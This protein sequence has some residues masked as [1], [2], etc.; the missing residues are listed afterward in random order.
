M[1]SGAQFC[2]V[3]S[4]ILQQFHLATLSIESDMCIF[5][6]ICL[7]CGDFRVAFSFRFCS[8]SILSIP[9]KIISTFSPLILFLFF[10]LYHNI[11]VDSFCTEKGSLQHSELSVASSQA[12]NNLHYYMPYLYFIKTTFSGLSFDCKWQGFSCSRKTFLRNV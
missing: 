12:R 4:F 10:S 3:F 11:I 2:L 7:Q 6:S 8:Y 9:N 1:P 5:L